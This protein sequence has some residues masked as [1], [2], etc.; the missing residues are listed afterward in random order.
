MLGALAA[1]PAPAAVAP[2]ARRPPSGDASAVRAGDSYAAV[3]A[4]LQAYPAEKLPAGDDLTATF[5]E[6]ALLAY[7][8]AGGAC[9]LSFARGRLERCAG[10]DPLRFQCHR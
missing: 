7:P 10:C 9:V 8:G 4:A 5:R 3:M 1:R 2:E 6:P